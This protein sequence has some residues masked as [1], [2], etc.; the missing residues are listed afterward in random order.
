MGLKASRGPAVQSTKG[1]EQADYSL[2]H[3]AVHKPRWIKLLLRLEQN[4]SACADEALQAVFGPRETCVFWGAA[5]MFPLALEE[6][7]LE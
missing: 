4:E 6:V 5:Q 2:W 1:K 3:P 7:A